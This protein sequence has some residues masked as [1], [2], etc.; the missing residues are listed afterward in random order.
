[1]H[2][3]VTRRRGLSTVCP[4]SPAPGPPTV[5]LGRRHPRA[6]GKL[7][8]ALDTALDPDTAAQRAGIAWFV[9][10]PTMSAA[11][12]ATDDGFTSYQAQVGNPPRTRWGDDGA[13]PVDGSTV[14]IASDYVASACDY[15]TWGGRFFGG[16]TGDHKLGTG[17]DSPGAAAS[18]T[19]LGNGSTRISQVTP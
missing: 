8:G 16:T 19:A 17:A 15:S 9:V 6:N 10:K 11:G 14:W 18:R 12:Q 7:W 2:G 3:R 5:R 4:S 1:M 13:A